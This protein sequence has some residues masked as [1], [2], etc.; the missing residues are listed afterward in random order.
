MA[1]SIIIII[2]ITL[3]FP[4]RNPNEAHPGR[5]PRSPTGS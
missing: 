2:I 3:V 1:F 4:E 5:A